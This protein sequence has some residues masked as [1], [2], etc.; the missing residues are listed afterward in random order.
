MMTRVLSIILTGLFVLIASPVSAF[1]TSAPNALVMDF[2]TGTVLFDKNANKAIPPASMSKL[3]TVYMVFEAIKSGRL[4]LDDTFLVSEKAWRM[5][6]SKMFV[7]VGENIA[8]RDLLRGIIIQSG[9]DACI[10]VAEGLAGSEETFAVRMTDKAKELGLEQSV[11]ANSSGLPDP[12]HRM[13]LMDLAKLAQIIITEFP[14]LYKIYSETSFEWEGINQNN[15]NPLLYTGIG[16]DG[17]KTGHTEEAGYGL[18]GS[19]VQEGRRIIIAV[20]GLPSDGARKQEAV[21]LMSWG[22]REF[23]NISLFDANEALVNAPV[24]MG[25]KPTVGVVLE[26]PLKISIPVLASNDVKARIK[27]KTPL[28]APV[29]KGTQVGELIVVAGDIP[30]IRAPVVAA[31]GVAEGNVLVKMRTVVFQWLEKNLNLRLLSDF[32]TVSIAP[33]NS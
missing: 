31:E 8:I 30:A 17:L 15:R 4:S 3:M 13:S 2:E 21:R 24:W 14:D 16:A 26:Q 29:E 12:S 25:E 22:F 6:G 27:M 28:E 10:V 32:D 19:A 7:R 9:N 5:G 33:K 20:S 1:E 18:V 11:F 23:R